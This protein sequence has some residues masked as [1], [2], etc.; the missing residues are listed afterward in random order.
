MHAIVWRRVRPIPVPKDLSVSE[1][2]VTVVIPTVCEDHQLEAFKR[3]LKTISRQKPHKII[4]ITPAVRAE[5]IRGVTAQIHT[6]IEVV[7]SPQAS[8]REQIWLGLQ[9]VRTKITVCADDDVE[10]RWDPPGMRC[11][12]APFADPYTGAVGTCQRVER[13]CWNPVE[14][15]GAIYILRR[16]QETK[17][18]SFIDGGLS[19]L[20]GR[21]FAIRTCILQQHWF[22]QGYRGEKWHGRTLN[23]DDDNFITRFLFDG[24]WKVQIQ[25]AEDA[26]VYTTLEPTLR[27][28]ISQCIRWERSRWRHTFTL[29]TKSPRVWTYV[30][31][32]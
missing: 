13:T 7:D 31:K 22:G 6:S 11:L 30:F 18:T 20:S 29:V 10:W 16:N 25:S 12:L 26:V 23:P 15:L 1:E 3:T 4:V 5:T 8:K 32:P 9:N 27:K 17:A 28:Y 24:G 21:T 2:D 14:L 19:C